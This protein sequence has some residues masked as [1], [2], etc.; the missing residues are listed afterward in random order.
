MVA[1]RKR[2]ENIFCRAGTTILFVAVEA[3]RKLSSINTQLKE[4]M[5]VAYFINYSTSCVSYL[6]RSTQKMI[7]T[8]S[9]KI[10]AAVVGLSLSLAIFAGANVASA[11]A[12][13]LSQLVD[14]F[15]TLGIISPDKAAAAKAA[16]SSSAT[17]SV[18][19]T[20]DLTV[21]S[22][23]ADV[24]A[25]QT[26]FGSLVTG[27]FGPITKAAAQAYQ[28]TN[29]II[30]TGYVGPL[31]RAALNKTSTVTTTT[32]GT[33]TTVVNTGIE[34][35]LTV[36]K[37]SVS[38]T[39]IYEG[40]SMKSVLG[41]KLEA[42][43]A[44]VSVQRVKLD[45]GT[46]SSFYTKV[47]K[48]VYLS[49]DSGAVI[50]Q[51]DLNSNTVVK[52][53][54]RY[55]LTLGGFNYVVS[56]DSTKNLLVKADA[57][58]SIGSDDRYSRTVTLP[59]DG[60]RGVDQAG[61]DQYSPTASFSQSISLSAALID[62][63]TLDLSLNSANF[64]TNDV[65]ADNG[66]ASNEL[67]KLPLLAF[68]IRASKDDVTVTDLNIGIT[69]S[70]SATIPTVYLYEGSTLI[71]SESLNGTMVSFTDINNL[72]VSKDGTKTI[73]VMVNVRDAATSVT[74]ISATA[75]STSFSTENSIGDYATVSGSANGE[76]MN[77]R[78]IGP[79]FTL[80]SKSISVSG[81]N[82]SGATLS[83]ST[84][85]ASF[86]VTVTAKGGDIYFGSQ[87]S[88]TNKMFAFS[89][90]DLAGSAAAGTVSTTS[91][92]FAIPSSGVTNVGTDGFKL[93]KNNSV[94]ID[95]IKVTVNGKGT[96]G[97]PILGTAVGISAINWSTTAGIAPT[98]STFMS[99]ETEWR[100][101]TQNP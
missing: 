88:T 73:T 77:V 31:T 99:G 64:K 7:K 29:G 28:A 19:F 78:S 93:S 79:V 87:A 92:G 16:V 75:S 4:C 46:S 51:A 91:E 20:R 22:T 5:T 48:R 95:G 30:T 35:T 2:Y 15:I 26:R 97:S 43:L 69:K 23:G 18:E 6:L 63:S 49:D 39:T 74:A 80:N 60:V 72:V 96:D 53:G 12:M 98:T 34:G 47:F 65:V 13:T 94:T 59:V 58:S 57:Y 67:D 9:S 44:D 70:G 8:N 62:S 101:T 89:L 37:A 33:T 90:Y 45:L 85:T 66:A 1:Q 42:K 10:V 100:T 27:Y 83:T 14:L 32:P 38:N 55:Y 71:A 17:V 41:I 84:I 82:S 56:K 50:A 86:S 40:N 68:D 52:D 24:S 3:Q 11:Q 21:G 54:G 61:I 25:L 76:T 36:N 81:A